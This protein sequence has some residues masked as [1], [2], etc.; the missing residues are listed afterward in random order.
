MGSWWIPKRRVLIPRISKCDLAWRK[1]FA[2]INQALNLMRSV[3]MR[4]TKGNIHAHRKSPHENEDRDKTCSHKPRKE[5]DHRKLEETRNETSLWRFRKDHNP[6][7]TL[8]SNFWAPE[9]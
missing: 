7:D 4:D 1:D 3:L 9:L 2:E 8:I 6:A 5:R